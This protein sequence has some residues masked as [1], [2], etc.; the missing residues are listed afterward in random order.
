MQPKSFI[1]KTLVS[2]LLMALGLPAV[3]AQT[4]LNAVT[5]TS[6]TIGDR[7]ESDADIPASTTFIS[8][9]VVEEKHAQ[10]LIEVLRSIPGITADLAGEGDGIKIK[11]RG[12]DNQRYMGEKPG[13]A[14]VIDGVPVFERTG[15]VNVDLDNI[16][17]IRVVKGG[18]SYLFGEDA[19]AGAIIITTKRGASNAG[20][21]L[22]AD[23]GSY[24]YTR[25]LVKAGIAEEDFAGHVQ[26]SD[27]HNDGYYALSERDAE[28]VS[29][30]FEYYLNDHSELSFGFEEVERF[31][32]RDG[33]VRGVTAAEENP[34][35]EGEGRGYTRMFNVDLS[36]LNLTYSND[37]SDTGNFSAIVYQ[38]EDITDFWSSPIKVDLDGSFVGDDQV[39]RYANLNYYE[40]LQRGAKLEARES[41]GDF[42]LMG[43]LEV[44]KNTYDS[45]TVAKEDYSSRGRL[46][47]EGTVTS[48]SYLE[49][50]T[51][52]VYTEA[53]LAVNEQTTLTANYRFDNIALDDL[54]Q[55][56]GERR[57]D[58]F[59]IHSWRVGADYDLTAQT[60]LYGSISTGF[61]TPT[62]SEMETNAD[63]KPETNMNYEIGARTQASLFGW[64]THINSSLFYINRKDFITAALGQYANGNAA[65]DDVL[66]I[67]DNIGHTTSKG[68]ELAMQT[69]KKHNWSF[70]FAYTFMIN[71]FVDYD[72]FFLALGNPYART[73]VDSEAELVDPMNQVYFKH[74][75]NGGNYVPRSPKHMTNVRAHWYPTPKLTL[76]TE[77][78]YRGESYADEINQEKMPARTLVNLGM[79]YVTKAQ[80]L[81]GAASTLTLF[82]KV[83]NLF[84]DQFYSIV[85]G[86]SDSDY[87]GDYDAEDLS[88]NVDPGRVYMA[89][90]KVKF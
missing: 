39:D 55:R 35:G 37:F 17:S 30:N 84:D 73:Q 74:Y 88:I 29:G 71:K 14:I 69:E 16:A 79:Q 41:F 64:K 44:K 75:D 45:K 20:V 60:S 85:R 56:S 31:R 36:R 62:L 32:D 1:K 72:N 42:A 2:S 59:N 43:G 11:I 38:Y 22:E 49:E 70:D 3:Q 34:T 65:T 9:E 68:F 7:F 46:V 80:V 67:Y 27:R 86:T 19:L 57:E 24:G 6:S 15:K 53:K 87:D 90:F 66:D 63:L 78:D 33:S 76:T 52:A 77:I 21:T 12:V 25:T 8:G 61:R 82:F 4:E 13:V 81:G 10:N 40:Q 18:A 23:M 83:D 58:T 28:A 51:K 50:I 47:A 54:D 89:G 48:D 5:V 26:I